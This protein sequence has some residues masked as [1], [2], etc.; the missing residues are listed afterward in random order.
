MILLES[1]VRIRF[2]FPRDSNAMVG[3]LEVRAR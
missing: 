1:S 3:K 2:T